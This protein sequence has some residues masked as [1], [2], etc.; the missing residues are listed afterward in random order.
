MAE[1]ET[2]ILRTVQIFLYRDLIGSPTTLKVLWDEVF[3]RRPAAESSGGRRT[4]QPPG[5]YFAFLIGLPHNVGYSGKYGV[6]D[7]NKVRIWPRPE[8]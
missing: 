2:I 5:D 4:V 1:G 8:M 7:L 3:G 6:S